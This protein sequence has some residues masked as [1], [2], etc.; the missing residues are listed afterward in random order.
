MERPDGRLP[1]GRCETGLIAL[2]TIRHGPWRRGLLA[3]LLGALL[4]GP[5]WGQEVEAE[6]E[7]ASDTERDTETRRLDIPDE[8]LQRHVREHFELMSLGRKGG[9]LMWE[10]GPDTWGDRQ[11]FAFRREMST[12]PVHKGRIS[13]RHELDEIFFAREAPY[14]F[15]AAQRSVR[16]DKH[17]QLSEL[18]REGDFYAGSIVEDGKVRLLNAPFVEFSY[19]DLLTPVAWMARDDLL[20][21]EERTYLDLDYEGLKPAKRTLR[22][23]SVREHVGAGGDEA[24]E[25]AA[26][27]AAAA[28]YEIAE[29]KAVF[30][31]GPYQVDDAGR[32]VG[33][34]YVGYELVPAEEKQARLMQE[35]AVDFESL[36]RWGLKKR[37]GDTKSI[38]ELVLETRHPQ[39]AELTEGPGQ[40]VHH[41]PQTGTTTLFLGATY[42]SLEA[43]TEQDRE[44]ALAETVA[45]PIHDARVKRLAATGIRK[46]R[47]EAPRDQLEALLLYVD[48]YI[49]ND[50]DANPDSLDELLDEKLGDCTEHALMFLTLARSLGHPVRPVN[51]YVHSGDHPPELAA[52]RWVEVALDGFWQPMDPSWSEPV[53]NATHVR[54]GLSDGITDRFFLTEGLTFEV[55]RLGR[56]ERIWTDK[57]WRKPK[58]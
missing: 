45:F 31:M 44:D 50:L 11:V 12:R 37:I 10:R 36:S 39:A 29:A 21:G 14:E 51:G 24:G 56:G 57:A 35:R 32:L 16:V 8:L 38:T 52:H 53:L 28:R 46:A 23:V 58:R 48:E 18:M 22:V 17:F 5:V 54:T 41:D 9:W 4:S 25:T 1:V 34:R 42:G 40:E 49:E 26:A 30:G 19:L 55:K 47:S 43:V 27:S 15:L 2:G 33:G 7:A 20:A 3:V 6:T 13:N